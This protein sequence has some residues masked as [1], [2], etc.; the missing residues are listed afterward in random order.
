[1]IKKSIKTGWPE[2]LPL[3]VFFIK[4][5][6]PCAFI[7][8]QRGRIT[9]EQFNVLEDA[10]V[11]NKVLYRVEIEKYFSP[12]FRR[13]KRLAVEKSLKVWSRELMEEYYL[14]G[15]NRIIDEG[16][17]DYRSAPPVLKELCKV[18]PGEIT[19][20]K[21]LTASVKL[22]NGKTRVVNLDLVGPVGKG[23]RVFVHYGYAVG[24]CR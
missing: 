3:E 21:G 1:M 5:A 8:L 10:A 4:F 20:V 18:A 11:N 24:I 15:H 14:V 17:E 6:F 9:R 23:E 19:D 13:M 22:E 16:L 7:A 2:N 12:A